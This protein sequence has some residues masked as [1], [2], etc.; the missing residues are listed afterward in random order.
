M[1]D[2]FSLHLYNG[3][4]ETIIEKEALLYEKIR[5]SRSVPDHGAVHGIRRYG[6]ALGQSDAVFLHAGSAAA[7]HRAGV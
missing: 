5:C 7:G 1:I 4:K 2:K 6:R 3:N